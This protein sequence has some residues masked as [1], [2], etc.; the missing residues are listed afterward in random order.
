MVIPTLLTEQQAAEVLTIK[1]KTLQKWRVCGGGPKF[2][3]LGR[4]V[5]YDSHSLLE[6]VREHTLASTAEKEAHRSAES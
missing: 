2:I 1:V 4:A 3:K 5:R 6:F